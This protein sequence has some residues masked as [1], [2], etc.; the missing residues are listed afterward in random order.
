MNSNQYLNFFKNK[1]ILITGNTGFI[2]SYLS[3]TLSL[4]GAKVFGYSLKKKNSRY[5]SNSI[6]YKKKIKTLVDDIKNIKKYKRY[7]NE[8]SPST[9]I[10]L[11]SQPLVGESYKKTSE[12]YETNILGTVKLL[13]LIKEIKSVKNILI[14]TSDKVYRNT[15]ANYLS[16]NSELGGIDPYSSSKSCQDI[17]AYS[18]KESF[19]KKDKN[20]FIIRAGNIIGGGDWEISRLIPDIYNS[21]FKNKNFVIRN[22][23]A[24]RP[25][26]HVLDVINCILMILIRSHKKIFKKTMIYNIGPS[27]KSNITVIDLVK[28]IKKSYPKLKFFLSKKKFFKETRILKLSNKLVVKNIGWKPL[29]NINQSIKL[30]NLWYKNYYQLKNNIFD[31]TETQIKNFFKL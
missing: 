15:R 3:L 7:L 21:I 19:F 17:I 24:I 22:S 1:K 5:L 4:M 12:T 6:K 10:H 30:I 28:K 26:Q 25:W 13:E 16:E 23:K 9:I 18:Y 14:F 27:N 31:I 11:A 29:I 20:M 8:V 2:G